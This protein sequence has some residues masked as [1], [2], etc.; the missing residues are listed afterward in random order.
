MELLQ[1][2][3]LELDKNYCIIITIPIRTWYT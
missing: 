1:K 3:I 2:I